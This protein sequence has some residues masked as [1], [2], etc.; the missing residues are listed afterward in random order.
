[1]VV[2]CGVS[3]TQLIV[4]KTKKIVDLRTMTG[5]YMVIVLTAKSSHALS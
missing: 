1:M 4:E 2:K 5:V 3:H